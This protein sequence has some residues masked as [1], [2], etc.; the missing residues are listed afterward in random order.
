LAYFLFR[1]Y[2]G[3]YILKTFTVLI[4]NLAV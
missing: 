4:D 1:Y 3:D 2:A